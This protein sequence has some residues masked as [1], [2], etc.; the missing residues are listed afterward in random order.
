MAKT[1]GS[2]AKNTKKRKVESQFETKVNTVEGIVE[3]QAV[4]EVANEPVEQ[5]QVE[6]KET[7]VEENPILKKEDDIEVRYN[8]SDEDTREMMNFTRLTTIPRFPQN[9]IWVRAIAKV[10][11]IDTSVSWVVLRRTGV[12][13]HLS[14]IH[15]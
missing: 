7:P 3:P 12:H 6:V 4:E 13:S 15:I 1:R 10:L 11:K 2:S 5:E 8:V 14:L 9:A